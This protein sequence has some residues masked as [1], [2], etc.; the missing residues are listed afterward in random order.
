MAVSFLDRILFVRQLLD[1]S[2]LNICNSGWKIRQYVT[3]LREVLFSKNYFFQ[4]FQQNCTQER[5]TLHHCNAPETQPNCV[6]CLLSSGWTLSLH[7]VIAQYLW[8]GT[9]E[10]SRHSLL[11]EEDKLFVSFLAEQDNEFACGG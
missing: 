9:R 3:K 5:D 10:C 6:L 11:L 1:V 7:A 2:C 4:Q 8:A